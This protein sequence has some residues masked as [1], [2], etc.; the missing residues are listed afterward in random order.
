MSI[1]DGV[2]L[3]APNFNRLITC[4]LAEHALISP[5]YLLRQG[6]DPNNLQHGMT[7]LNFMRELEQVLA[8]K[9]QDILV[10]FAARHLS[11]YNAMAL[12]NFFEGSP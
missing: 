12:Q 9:P 1:G 2:S 4:K 8:P 11:V 5:A 10:T 7:A 3:D 6:I